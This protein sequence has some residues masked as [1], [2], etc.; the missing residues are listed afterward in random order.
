M[1]ESRIDHRA[2]TEARG[3]SLD[4]ASPL[5]RPRRRLSRGCGVDLS[6]R[7]AVVLAPPLA[8][9]LRDFLVVRGRLPRE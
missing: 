3:R 8:V 4:G 6:S 7:L 5:A 9:A 1:T 2:V